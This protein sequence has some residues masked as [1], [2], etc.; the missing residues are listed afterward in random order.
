MKWL[1]FAWFSLC[2]ACAQRGFLPCY[3]TSHMSLLEASTML[4]FLNFPA[5]KPMCQINR[6][7]LWITQSVV[8]CYSNR[9]KLIY[10]IINLSLYFII[11]VIIIT[12]FKCGI[13]MYYQSNNF[14]KC[15]F[16]TLKLF[17]LIFYPSSAHQQSPNT[18]LNEWFDIS[19]RLLVHLNIMLL[20]L[21]YW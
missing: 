18:S 13:T 21:H 20:L 4:F 5:S 7:H 11:H 14:P 6:Y 1:Y 8:F 15:P 12:D 19:V 16:A 9:K 10:H 3:D 17:S 2:L